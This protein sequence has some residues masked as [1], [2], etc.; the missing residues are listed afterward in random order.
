MQEKT[1]KLFVSQPMSGL[2]MDQIIKDREEAANFFKFLKVTAM[3][4]EVIDNLQE[5]HPEY[6]ATDYLSNDIKLL[7]RADGIIFVKGW[8]THRGCLVEFEVARNFVDG[9]DMYFM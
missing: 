4:I 2:S 7:G 8:E 9:I 1:Y 5:D 3:Q 6:I